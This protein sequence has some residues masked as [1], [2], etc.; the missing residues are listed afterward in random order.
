MSPV[1]HLLIGWITANAVK[2]D[3][4]ERVVVTIAGVIPDLDGVGIVGEILT[5]NS[6]RPLTWFSDYHHLLGHNLGFCLLVT[7]AAFLIASHRW[8]TAALACLSFH[9]H[10]F[11]D[12]I[13]ARG[14]DLHQWPIPYLLPFSSAWQW[15]WSGQWPLNGWPNF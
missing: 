12:L 9:L 15:T 6:D 11:C 3:R 7:L 13:G 2:L 5:R 1:T 8:K 14:P 10:L 4:R